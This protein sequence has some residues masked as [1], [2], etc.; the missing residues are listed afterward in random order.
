VDAGPF[1][2]QTVPMA[3]RARYVFKLEGSQETTLY[4]FNNQADGGFPAASLIADEAGNLYGATVLG[5]DVSCQLSPGNPPGCGVVFKVSPSGEE[6][7]LYTFTGSTDGA[8]PSAALVKDS[9]GSLY[10]AAFYGSNLTCNGGSGCGTIFKLHSAGKFSVLHTFEGSD[11]KD[12]KPLI[13]GS[14]R[15]YSTASGGQ[16]GYGVVYELPP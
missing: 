13:E 5:G 15:L 1:G 3:I 7:V 10:G 2:A 6:T 16:S 8:W 11:G 4:S 9:P 14:G 12:P